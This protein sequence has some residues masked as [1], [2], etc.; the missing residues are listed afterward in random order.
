MTKRRIIIISC[1]RPISFSLAAYLL[2]YRYARQTK[3]QMHDMFW[4][5]HYTSLVTIKVSFSKSVVTTSIVPLAHSPHRLIQYLE[6]QCE[7]P[8]PCFLRIASVLSSISLAPLSMPSTSMMGG[9]GIGGGGTGGTGS[10][11]GGVGSSMGG[12]MYTSTS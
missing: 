10:L 2:K 12:P 7:V 11:T 6:G 4:L 5:Q 1:R 8:P 3:Q 9:F